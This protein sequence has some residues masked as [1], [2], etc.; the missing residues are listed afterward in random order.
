MKKIICVCVLIVLV[1]LLS[2]CMA[3]EITLPNGERK[4]VVYN[5]YVILNEYTNASSYIYF[6]YDIR[7]NV[8]YTII[9]DGSRLTIVPY[10]NSDGTLLNKENLRTIN[11]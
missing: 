3:K 2:G 11:Y 1:F 10:Y 7:T 4:K 8:C 9:T 5:F 6:T